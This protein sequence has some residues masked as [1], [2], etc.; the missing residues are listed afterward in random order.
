MA[1]GVLGSELKQKFFVMSFPQSSV[2]YSLTSAIS[3]RRMVGS[4][5]LTKNP[6]PCGR[7]YEN[8]VRKQRTEDR[9]F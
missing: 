1:I 6:T 5:M 3:V 7:I 4:N 8:L 9:F 2:I